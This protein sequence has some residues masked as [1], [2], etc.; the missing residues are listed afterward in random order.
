MAWLISWI[1]IIL[2]CTRKIPFPSLLS[3]D[4]IISEN[5]YLVG[6][7]GGPEEGG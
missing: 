7:D 5:R 2:L 6:A 3:M 4:D 1:H